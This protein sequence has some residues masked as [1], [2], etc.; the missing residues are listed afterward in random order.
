MTLT[1]NI[2]KYLVVFF[3]ISLSSCATEEEVAGWQTWHEQY[4]ED[5]CSRCPDCCIETTEEGFIDPYGVERPADWLPESDGGI[6]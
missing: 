5:A 6:E 3:S 2:T 4:V 1:S